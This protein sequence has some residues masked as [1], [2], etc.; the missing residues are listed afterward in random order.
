M[1]VCSTESWIHPAVF[2]LLRPLIGMRSISH[3]ASGIRQDHIL[4]RC[5]VVAGSQTFTQFTF[6]VLKSNWFS[7]WQQ[8]SLFMVVAGVKVINGFTS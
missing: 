8:P 4:H 7:S 3:H 5:Q 6:K 1:Q 2:Y